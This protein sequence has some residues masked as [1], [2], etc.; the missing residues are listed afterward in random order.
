M[1]ELK[2]E[3][4]MRAELEEDDML[5]TYTQDDTPN[6]QVKKSAKSTKY[7]KKS[8]AAKAAASKRCSIASS[9]E[10]ARMQS[11]LDIQR[12]AKITG[13]P[14]H[15]PR[16]RPSL[17]KSKKGK[18]VEGNKKGETASNGDVAKQKEVMVNNNTKYHHNYRD[19]SDTDDY[20]SEEEHEVERECAPTQTSTPLSSKG[21]GR[22]KTGRKRV[23]ET[24]PKVGRPLKVLGK[25][26][27][28]LGRP[29][30]S[31]AREVPKIVSKPGGMAKSPKSVA[32]KAQAKPVQAVK[33]P[34]PIP[35]HVPITV[36]KV[37]GKPQKIVPNVVKSY[38]EM[39]VQ[40]KLQAAKA[41]VVQQKVP[42]PA[43]AV[44]IPSPDDG[45][46]KSG[47]ARRPSVR[48]D[49]ESNLTDITSPKFARMYHSLLGGQLVI[50]STQ[51]NVA[52]TN[53]AI[54][55]AI[56]SRGA[57]VKP[58]SVMASGTKLT[59]VNSA[60]LAGTSVTLGSVGLTSQMRVNKILPTSQQNTQLAASP[61]VV[62]QDISTAMKTGKFTVISQNKQP[63]HDLQKTPIMSNHMRTQSAPAQVQKQIQM[64]TPAG[65]SIPQTSQHVQ[66]LAS[67]VTS[68]SVAQNVVTQNNNICTVQCD[69]TGQGILMTSDG[70]PL[71]LND[72]AQIIV[73]QSPTAQVIQSPASTPGSPQ[74][75]NVAAISQQLQPAQSQPQQPMKILL[76]QKPGGVVQQPALGGTPQVSQPQYVLT[77]NVQ[78]KQIVSSSPTVQTITAVTKPAMIQQAKQ[79][80]LILNSA[81]NLVASHPQVVN[82]ANNAQLVN[83]SSILN[84][85]SPGTIGGIRTTRQIIQTNQ[86]P[87]LATIQQPQQQTLITSNNG[88]A[89]RTIVKPPTLVQT[90]LP[91]QQVRVQ[92]P[93]VVRSG[94]QPTTISVRA[95]VPPQ[96]VNSVRAVV[97]PTVQSITSVRS[98]IQSPP[99]VAVR[100]QTLSPPVTNA[101]H[102]V[103]LNQGRSKV[104]LA[105]IAAH[106]S[107]VMGT[108]RQRLAAVTALK[109]G[110][111]VS[112]ASAIAPQTLASPQSQQNLIVSQS[113]LVSPQ[114][115]PRQVFVLPSG[116][117]TQNQ[118]IRTQ[119][120]ALPTRA[121]ALQQNRVVRLVTGNNNGTPRFV[122][123][124]HAVQPATT[125]IRAATAVTSVQHNPVKPVPI[126]EKLTQQL[127]SPTPQM[128]TND[129]ANNSGNASPVKGRN[130]FQDI[131]QIT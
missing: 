96:S 81:G 125:M 111:V 32:A 53:A 65:L 73:Q 54:Q 57:M 109:H 102:V 44:F 84:A 10:Y 18:V 41:N 86:G 31:L 52:T 29:S 112:N 23:L 37:V 51:N 80:Q 68:L 28:L 82:T 131:G 62:I 101:A 110:G 19:Y 103:R 92:Q 77:S 9:E 119:A 16:G 98:S 3:E 1:K 50:T 2:E 128:T 40:K 93:T 8:A 71:I 74:S 75:V 121:P 107:A 21:R 69:S 14:L 34:T 67:P 126:L 85:V 45:S 63:V 87:V 58:T 116:T 13:Q 60:S 66:Q 26:Q 55:H 127:N 104:N 42:K 99:T 11:Q 30:K 117:T 105:T 36:K 12:A 122:N 108:V 5:F 97:Q 22:G 4:E 118:I 91:T 114:N 17:G 106:K 72:S 33:I 15:S 95:T 89:G 56:Q 83:N 61:K 43:P 115:Q 123:A 46:R 47:R 24:T 48:L 129:L 94:M 130:L 70:T 88:I 124:S 49:L 7:V 78:G 25:A 120:V 79:P 90:S 100:S 76:I 39:L 38:K 64:S 35:N 20:E 27:K 59:G 6:N 113:R